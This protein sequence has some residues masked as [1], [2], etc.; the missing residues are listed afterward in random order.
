MRQVEK[1]LNTG[2]SCLQK[3]QAQFNIL[4]LCAFAKT[5][6]YLQNSF[7]HASLN[8]SQ[9]KGQVL[10]KSSDLRYFFFLPLLLPLN[11]S[12]MQSEAWH[13]QI[14]SS[15]HTK[16]YHFIARIS[17]T[18]PEHSRVT[19]KI[20][21]WLWISVV[22]QDFMPRH[23]PLGSAAAQKMCWW[24][25]ILSTYTV[26]AALRKQGFFHSCWYAFWKV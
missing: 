9:F 26:I 11:E 7:L 8:P 16:A 1:K 24:L 25:S 20:Y 12:Q 21:F 5:R 6:K 14:R 3:L 22:L 2:S 13:S 23:P 4:T 19:G 10:F 18:A 15:P 17:T